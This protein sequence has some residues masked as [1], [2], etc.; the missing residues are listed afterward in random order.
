MSEQET[1]AGGTEL[2]FDQVAQSSDSSARD[3]LAV[4]CTACHE[5]LRTEY[6]SINGRIVCERCSKMI[7]RLAVPPKGARPLIRAGMFGLCA[8]I[9]GAAVYYAVLAIAHLEIGIVAIL[10]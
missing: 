7:E 10:I 3:G 5:S 8:G 1:A 2:Q 4:E 6:F 9:A